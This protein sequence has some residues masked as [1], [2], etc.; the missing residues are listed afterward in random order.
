[1]SR[2]NHSDASTTTEA[3]ERGLKWATQRIYAASSLLSVTDEGVSV[4][5]YVAD[6]IEH[7][8]LPTL[9][10]TAWNDIL[11]ATDAATETL[12][13]GQNALAEGHPDIAANAGR[14][15]GDS[16]ADVS[17]RGMRLLGWALEEQDDLESARAAYRKAARSTDAD[18][19]SA[20]TIDIGLLHESLQNYPTAAIAYQSSSITAI[21]SDD[22]W[23]P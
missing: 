10:A 9:P 23:Q 22:P 15:V 4:F 20:A 16:N 8:H 2:D 1:M 5:D 19:A 12:T 13:V 18:V 6:A 3:Y 11:D 17:A 7:H 14:T 21:R